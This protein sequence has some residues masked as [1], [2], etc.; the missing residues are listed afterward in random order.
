MRR[1]YILNKWQFVL[2][3]ITLFLIG[4]YLGSLFSYQSSPS[5]AST[6][7]GQQVSKTAVVQPIPMEG[8]P[9]FADIAEQAS[10]AVVK[11]TS[12]YRYQDSPDQ[13]FWRE[14]F[15]WPDPGEREGES[16]GTGFLIDS[17]GFIIT[18]EHVIR[19]A[20]RL[21]VKM[22]G[23][24]NPLSVK[25]VGASEDLDL[26]LLKLEDGQNPYPYLKLGNSD[27]IRVGEWV[28]AI[29]NPMGL[30]HTVTVGVVSAKDRPIATQTQNG[31]H[32]YRNLI[33]T[34]AAIN[35]GNS[36][37]PL[38]NTKGEVVGISAMVMDVRKTSA[39]GIGFAIASNTVKNSLPMLKKGGD[40][41]KYKGQGWLGAT[42][43]DINEYYRS[44]LDLPPDLQGIVITRIIING[45]AYAAGIQ[46]GDVI[47]A[48]NNV[49]AVNI[50]VFSKEMAKYKINAAV[51]LK[52]Y[53]RGRTGDLEVVLKKPPQSC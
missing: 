15:G 14:F 16:F 42:L 51:S 18:N 53:R 38:L 10:P 1:Y 17:S 8:T 49:N 9:G 39:V 11:V 43:A 31:P 29:G 37:G 4:I 7:G 32:T 35:P 2:L 40:D 33:Q 52:I 47:L 19:N 45:P 28:L 27:R 12:Y 50:K 13:R 24:Q 3:I 26:A 23:Y 48:I 41:E 20:T 25:L 30:D 22:K 34:D 44:L 36:G 6:L 21:E 5:T 46:P